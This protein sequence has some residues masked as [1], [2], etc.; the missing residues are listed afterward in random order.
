MQERTKG[1]HAPVRDHLSSYVPRLNAVDEPLIASRLPCMR[2]RRLSHGRGHCGM[3]GRIVNVPIDVQGTLQSLPRHISDD[4]AVEAH[5]KRQ[6]LT[7]ADLQVRSSQVGIARVGRTK[8]R[9]H[10]VIGSV[11]LLVTC[12]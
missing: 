5:M 7:Q 11:T 2:I 6:L 12:P 4:G 10:T 1:W 8:G 3:R 9:S